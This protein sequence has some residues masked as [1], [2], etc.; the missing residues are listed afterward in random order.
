MKM[1]NPDEVPL[2]WD[3]LYGD[4]ILG[5]NVLRNLLIVRINDHD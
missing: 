3:R 2:Y 4:K 1:F 5:R